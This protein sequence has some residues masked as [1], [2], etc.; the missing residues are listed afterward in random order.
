VAAQVPGALLV[1]PD[2]EAEQW[3]AA[4]ARGQGLD[5][6]VSTKQRHG[7]REVEVSVPDA[8]VQ[9]PCRGA[10]GRRGQHRAHAG[11]R[12]AGLALAR[13]AAT[14]DVAVTHGLFIG[15]ALAQLRAAGVRHV[16]STDSVPHASNCVSV[17]P[18]LAEA[19]RLRRL[20]A[21]LHALP[22]LATAA[23]A[24]AAAS[25]SPR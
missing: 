16:W 3:V 7:D 19:A 17:A 22:W 11:H 6:L 8:A 9:R 15:D 12:G 1:A 20:V 13:G 2:E 5:F 18:L 24:L 4:A 25:A 14:V 10:A 21:A 23:A